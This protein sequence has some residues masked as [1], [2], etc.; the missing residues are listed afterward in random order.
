MF[1]DFVH[2]VSQF[3]IH[4]VSLN[5]NSLINIFSEQEKKTKLVVSKKVLHIESNLSS[6]GFSERGE[7]KMLNLW[8]F[9]QCKNYRRT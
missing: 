3:Y 2:P 6:D 5:I 1:A 7:S 4:Q 9:F 8:C